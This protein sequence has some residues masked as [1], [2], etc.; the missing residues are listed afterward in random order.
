MRARNGMRF[1]HLL[2]SD[3]RAPA[4]HSAPPASALSS[5]AGNQVTAMSRSSSPLSVLPGLPERRAEPR[6]A[7]VWVSVVGVVATAIVV[8]AAAVAVLA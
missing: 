4:A 1:S 7:S 8:L 5:P 3:L 2:G 6:H